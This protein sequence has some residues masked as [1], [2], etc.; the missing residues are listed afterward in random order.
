MKQAVPRARRQFKNANR[1]IEAP[2]RLLFPHND[3]PA[4]KDTIAA[5]ATLSAIG[6]ISTVFCQHE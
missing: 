2:C 3:S 6:H 5:T 1:T 4:A